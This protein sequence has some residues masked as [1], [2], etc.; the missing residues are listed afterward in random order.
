M[1]LKDHALAPAQPTVG[2]NLSL[3]SEKELLRLRTQID[4]VLGIGS[5]KS[6]DLGEELSV[7]LRTAKMLLQEALADDETAFGQKAQTAMVLQR[8]LQDL[9]KMR[10]ELYNAERLKELEQ[11]LIDAFREVGSLI[12]RDDTVSQEMFNEVKNAFFSSY[13]RMLAQRQEEAQ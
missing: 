2:I 10:T 11:M 3:L 13:E 1:A 8:L 5:L 12:A 9:V 4:E 6:I 7:Q